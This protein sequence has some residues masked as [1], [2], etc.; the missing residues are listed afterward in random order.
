VGGV[1]TCAFLPPTHPRL[2]GAAPCP[3]KQRLTYVNRHLG[4]C[5][6][7]ERVLLHTQV[8][9]KEGAMC[10]FKGLAGRL[11]PIGVHAA[12]IL[13]HTAH[14]LPYTSIPCPCT[15]PAARPCPVPAAPHP[16]YTHTHRC[17]VRRGQCMHSRAWLGGWAPLVSMRPSSSAWVAPPTVG[18]QGGRVQ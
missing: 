10:A 13:S 17:S 7:V 12:L 8:F 6:C 9:R 5:L 11:G 4:H 3:R 16:P 2:L 1:S 18:R 14:L 15:Q